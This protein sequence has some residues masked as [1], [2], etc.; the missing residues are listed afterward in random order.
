MVSETGIIEK[1]MT[2]DSSTNTPPSPPPEPK[3]KLK[4]KYGR[5]WD[6]KFADLTIELAC[7]SLGWPESKGGLGKYGHFR[8]A[9]EML[10]PD[11][12]W[13]DWLE[14]QIQSLCGYEHAVI[15]PNSEIRTVAWAGCGTSGKTFASGLY[16][17]VWWLAGMGE[18]IA[19]LTTTTKD[20]VRKRVWPVVQ[21]LY[22]SARRKLAEEYKLD[23]NSV[24]LGHLLDSKTTLQ[25]SKG[26]DKHAI[27]AI[28]VR[29]GETSKAVAN[30]QGQHA[31]RILIAIDEATQCPEA[32]FACV[33]NLRKACQDLTVL[34]IGNPETHLDP[35][36]R[37]CE[38]RSGWSS[39]SKDS[40]MWPTKGV[41]EWQIEPGVCLHFAGA[42][43]PNVLQGKTTIPFIY[44]LEDH[45]AALNARGE[46]SLAYWKYDAGFWAPEGVC[47]TVLSEPMLENHGAM[48]E[49]FVFR[50]AATVIAA[51]DPA[52]G[53]DKCI[54]RFGLLGDLDS[55]KMGLSL[56][57][58]IEISINPE[59]K[60]EAEYQIARQVK[61]HCEARG[62]KPEHF[63][64]DATGTG[65]GVFAVLHAQWSNRILRVEFG[66]SPS[67]EPVSDSDLRPASQAYDRRVTELW[68]GVRELVLADQL[69]GVDRDLAIEFCTRQFV[70]K[71][72]KY[73]IETK[74]QVK[75]R[76]GHSPDDADCVA[77]MVELARSLGVRPKGLSAARRESSF[78]A[79]VKTANEVYD[80]VY[81]DD[82]F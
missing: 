39:I 62:V 61:A 26:D 79:L 76:L 29:D 45:Q 31:P 80:S 82:S 70:M 37:V 57:E 63:G 48:V 78:A 42:L 32:I 21:K 30:I 10:F 49:R 53:G 77:V 52:F 40:A 9:A 33:P 17:F 22:H 41:P 50:Q 68:F 58:R 15:R 55:G 51:L 28:A 4:R 27:F 6:P 74:D 60:Q 25:A 71:G 59:D 3:R 75:P 5:T 34:V 13:H 72:P 20:M 54:L 56:S 19:I 38:P 8:K 69:A 65:R 12:V 24:N 81:S 7:F 1:T 23:V 43:S 2:T 67:D 44:T 11:L 16:I 47:N 64:M 73:A 14:A 35:H 66:G 46:Q 18:S 36:G